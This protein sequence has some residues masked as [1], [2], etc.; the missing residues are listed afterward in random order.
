MRQPRPQPFAERP[1]TLHRQPFELDREHDD[2]HVGQ[3]E[4]R[5]RK[6]EHREAHHEAVRPRCRLVRLRRRRAAPRSAPRRSACTSVSDTVGWTRCPISVVTGRLVKIDV[7][8][9]PCSS[10]HTQPP[11]CTRNGSSRPSFAR[12]L[13]DVVGGGDVAGDHRRRVARRQEQQRKHD[14]RDHRHDDERRAE[15]AEDV[16]DHVAATGGLRPHFFSTFQRKVTG[17]TITPERFDR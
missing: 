6:A 11:N 8:R 9:S 14:Q 17:A 13:L 5:H 16:D 10:R 4:H 7:P 1:V 15:A 2:E 12:M 3:H